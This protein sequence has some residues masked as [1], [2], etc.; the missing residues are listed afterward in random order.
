[1][2]IDMIRIL[3]TFMVL[4]VPFNMFAQWGKATNVRIEHNV[5]DSNGRAMLQVH[6]NMEVHNANGHQI[7]PILFVDSPAG[8]PHHWANGQNMTSDGNTYTSTYE[9]SYWNGNQ[10][11]IGIY[12]DSLNPK[13]G[14]NTYYAR[15]G[16]W[17]CNL[18]R[19]INDWDNTPFVTYDMTGSAPAQSPSY[20]V[21]PYMPVMPQQNQCGVCGGTGRCSI[22]GGTGVSPNHAP[23]IHA[24]CG[25]CG[26]TGHCSTCSGRGWN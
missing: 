22:C 4:I 23:G 11:W 6:F 26:G 20:N 21:Q 14:K 10:E 7:K 1:M 9:D 24:K 15:I 12:N 2:K 17:D 18:S 16:I 19:W 3:L 13:P 5:R 25:G 8:T